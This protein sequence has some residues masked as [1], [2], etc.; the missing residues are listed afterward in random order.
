MQNLQGDFPPVKSNEKAPEVDE[1]FEQKDNFE[2]EHGSFAK[3]L[4]SVLWII[5]GFLTFILFL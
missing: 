3:A 2:I 5:A 4:E 1:T